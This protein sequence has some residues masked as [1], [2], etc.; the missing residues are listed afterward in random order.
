M[1]TFI[2]IELVPAVRQPLVDLLR[3]LPRS[4]GVRWVTPHQLHITLKF[5]GEVGDDRID[6]VCAA[7]EAAAVQVSGFSLRIKGLGA[8]PNLRSPRVLWCG[9]EDPS[10]GCRQWVERADPLFEQLGFPPEERAFTPHITLG[11]SK[12]GSGTAALRRAL[13]TTKAP[14]TPEMR[15]AQVVVFESRLLPGGAQYTPVSTHPLG[16]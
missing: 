9:V 10:G 7:A 5:L 15:A 1:R 14:D 12:S 2:A 3:K 16:A 4:D 11:R 8:F 13:E 6:A